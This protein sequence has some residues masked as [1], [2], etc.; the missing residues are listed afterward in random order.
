LQAAWAGP[1]LIYGFGLSTLEAA[2]ILLLFAVSYSVGM[3]LLGIISDK[4]L[5]RKKVVC[6]GQA[7]LAL[8]MASFLGWTPDTPIWLVA[9]AFFVLPLLAACGNIVYAHA[10]EISPPELAPAAIT[11]INAFPLMIGAIFIQFTGMFVPAEVS[12]I[13][14]PQDLSHLWLVSAVSMGL[15]A[16]AYGIFIPE[17]PAM[18]ALRKNCH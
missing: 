13:S 5:T 7:L 12:L 10:K 9:A 16:L 6:C 1:L 2:H 15:S 8:L 18:L 14:H 11:W 17:S 3:P 4:L